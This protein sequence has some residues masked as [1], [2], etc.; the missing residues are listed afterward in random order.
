M[1]VSWAAL[2]LSGGPFQQSDDELPYFCGEEYCARDG[3]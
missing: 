2:G 3:A 1:M